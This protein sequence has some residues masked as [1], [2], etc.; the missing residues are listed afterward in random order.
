MNMKMKKMEVVIFPSLPLQIDGAG[1]STSSVDRNFN[2][3]HDS[4]WKEFIL[5][6]QVVRLIEPYP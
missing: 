6:D 4:K 3:L 1:L 2:P 5:L